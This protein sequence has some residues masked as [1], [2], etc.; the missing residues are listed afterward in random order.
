MR[1]ITYFTGTD[2]PAANRKA[3]LC[4]ILVVAIFI[5]IVCFGVVGL[6]IVRKRRDGHRLKRIIAESILQLEV[7][8]CHSAKRR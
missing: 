4:A 1:I 7:K 2:D 5:G 8:G 6:H 3:I